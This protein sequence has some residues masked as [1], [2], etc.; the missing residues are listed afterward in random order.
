MDDMSP[1]WF[2]EQAQKIVVITDSNEARELAQ[3]IYGA[4]RTVQYRKSNYAAAGMAKELEDLKAQLAKLKEAG[5]G[6]PA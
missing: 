2:E 6:R 3:N 5:E 1:A 4:G